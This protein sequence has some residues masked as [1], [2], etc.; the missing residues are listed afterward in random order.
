MSDV[1]ELADT[2]SA[3]IARNATTKE[4]SSIIFHT[5]Q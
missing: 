1:L 2:G 5:A 3:A 4:N